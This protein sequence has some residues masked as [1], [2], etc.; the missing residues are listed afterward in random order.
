[1]RTIGIK[2]ADG[3]FYSVL[4]EGTP[5]EKLLD[6]TT[7]HNNQT[8]IMVDLYR[9]EICSMEDAEYVDS[10]QI[11]NIMEHPN[12]EPTIS[13]TVSIDENNKLSA[14][15][16]DNET[17]NQSNATISLVSRT[18]EE[19]L[20]TDEYNISE[21]PTMDGMSLEGLGGVSLTQTEE[22]SLFEDS[23]DSVDS[24]ES[25]E[26]GESAEFTDEVQKTALPKKGGLLAAASALQE[27]LDD[28]DKTVVE[29]IIPDV[30]EEEEIPVE[31]SSIGDDIIQIEPP[32][33]DDS[34]LR[35]DTAESEIKAE[36]AEAEPVV[37]PV[38]EPV[39]EE[40]IVEPDTTDGF[41]ESLEDIG[42]IEN[43]EITEP[44]VEET[45]SEPE[46]E[47]VEEPVIEEAS[48]AEDI[49]EDTVTEDLGFDETKTDDENLDDFESLG[50]PVGDENDFDFATE[51]NHVRIPDEEPAGNTDEY[52]NIPEIT[53][54]DFS[55]DNGLDSLDDMDLD[56]PD[57][58]DSAKDSD[59]SSVDS[60]LD[61]SSDSLIS[62][63]I[64][65][66]NLSFDLP[67]LDEN[68]GADIEDKTAVD[69]TE[70]I[71]DNIEDTAENNAEDSLEDL[72]NSLKTEDSGLD[73]YDLPD[74]DET[75]GLDNLNMD[76]DI[77]SDISTDDSS[78]DEFDFPDLDDTSSSDF[79]GNSGSGNPLSFT[80]L[81]DKETTLGNSAEVDDE[82]QGKNTK[83]SVIICILCAIICVLATLF[84]ILLIPSKFGKKSAKTEKP[85]IEKV[86]EEN[87]DK[88]E[89]VKEEIVEDDKKEVIEE[90]KDVL[91]S[92]EEE[93]VIIE[94]A[95]D[96]KPKA[97]VVTEEKVKDITYKIKW[98]DTLWDISD[99][100]YKNP[101]RYRYIARYNN[102][103]N[104]DYIISGTYITIPSE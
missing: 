37:E 88:K 9:S 45:V 102:I 91:E 48:F 60:D 58:S 14:K 10:L 46:V 64:T 59:I 15:L 98:G 30:I 62:D 74:F 27:T 33:I 23:N 93:V 94:K 1:M 3:S 87:N 47:P 11:E 70:I 75:S 104:P 54:T 35:D 101:W 73:T 24:T 8:K 41:N 66:P 20:M 80:G 42:N 34:F 13:F 43:I 50:D 65:E 103:K 97:P 95:E 67:D 22:N 92:K 49:I 19:R 6:L 21:N 2:L 82:N 72:D 100:Y 79:S 39:V 90:K 7:A 78:L 32:V 12:G 36:E 5:Q 55:S 89:D 83:A 85:L 38:I 96:V 29:D 51:T 69:S 53:E 71:E 31:E 77:M 86:I 81:Y 44:V 57:V 76:D 99:T 56:L 25:A 16:L 4:K 61:I 63:D 52:D 26:S 40:T 68:L 84:V 17:G 18:L 28:G